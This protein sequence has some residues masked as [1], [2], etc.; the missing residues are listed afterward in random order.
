V[1]CAVGVAAAVRGWPFVTDRYPTS[2][3]AGLAP[4]Q[5]LIDR[6]EQAG[7]AAVW[8]FPEARDQGEQRFGLLRVGWQTEPYPDDLL[9]TF[10]YTAFGAVY[11]DTTRFEQPGGGWDR[12]LGEFAR[13]ERSRPAWA[14]AESGFHGAS[15]G[16]QIGPLQTVFLVR[17]KSPAGVLEALRQGRMYAVQ[18]TRELGFDVGELVA[19]G[20]GA[21]AAV[22]ETLKVPAGTPVEL[23]V[24]VEASDGRSH[25]VRVAVIANGRLRALERGA[26]P[27]A[28]TYREVT[29]GTP[30]VLRV[31]ARGAQQR[32]LTNPIFVRP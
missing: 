17:E 5:E 13:G 14:L 23:R 26:T 4:Y 12:L 8:S 30:L 3:P 21:T 29:D 20:G 10:R 25:D 31:D 9:R 18:R 19:T 6:V 28:V 11:E 22:G 24:S 32:V 7:G 15:A 27:L 2:A 16:K 1:L